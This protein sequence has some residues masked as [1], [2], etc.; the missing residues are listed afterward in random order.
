MRD[1]ATDKVNCGVTDIPER[2]LENKLHKQISHRVT[3]IFVGGQL[4]LIHETSYSM[5]ISC[6]MRHMEA[7]CA[8]RKVQS[9]IA[10][11]QL[12]I[13]R[14]A[15]EDILTTRSQSICQAAAVPQPMPAIFPN[16]VTS[17]MQMA[18]RGDIRGHDFGAG[19][20][21]RVMQQG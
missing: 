13:S 7:S 19:L 21:S 14:L 10:Q 9:S 11:N 4:Q 16:V 8:R 20:C 15:A 18:H 12:Q 5:F 6:C 1:H 17:T 3:C 2:D